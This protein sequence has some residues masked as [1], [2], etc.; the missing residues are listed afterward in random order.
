MSRL[1]FSPVPHGR[2]DV[3]CLALEEACLP[4]DDLMKRDR[5][6][7]HLAD[8]HGPIGYAGVEGLGP[9]RLLRSLVVLP[10][11]RRKGHGGLLVTHVEKF[12]R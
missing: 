10:S 11:R 4:I 2:Y 7:F 8:H 6:F 3:L 5:T 9:D 12:A 1:I